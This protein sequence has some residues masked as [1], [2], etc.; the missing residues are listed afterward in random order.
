[1][2][3]QNHNDKSMYFLE[4]V[5]AATKGNRSHFLYFIG[6][7]MTPS[8]LDDDIITPDVW[9]GI[10]GVSG[11]F[12]KNA[13]ID[14]YKEFDMLRF[15]RY[16]AE[17][18]TY[19]YC[20]SLVFTS[21][22]WAKFRESYGEWLE[23]HDAFRDACIAEN[24]RMIL[25][26]RAL[27]QVKRQAREKEQMLK[28]GDGDI[29]VGKI[30]YENRMRRQKAEKLDK[31]ND[32]PLSTTIEF[33]K[34]LTTDEGKSYGTGL[35]ESS[36]NQFSP[37]PFYSGS[38]TTTTYYVNN[39]D[40]LLRVM[41]DLSKHRFASTFFVTATLSWNPE[42]P[43][44]NP[45]AFLHPVGLGNIPYNC[46]DRVLQD[47][48][49]SVRGFEQAGGMSYISLWKLVAAYRLFP[50]RFAKLEYKNP[51]R[52]SK[53]YMMYSVDKCIS[54]INVKRL[55]SGRSVVSIIVYQK[56]K[57]NSTIDINEVIGD[58]S[59]L[60]EEPVISSVLGRTKIE[61]ALRIGMMYEKGLLTQTEFMNMKS[62]LL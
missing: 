37:Y 10:N 35:L 46:A 18:N 42:E 8:M 52:S 30:A 15:K 21:V 1:M 20:C 44:S 32:V 58:G 7:R 49:L 16:V 38:T 45:S 24:K 41:N 25:A 31:V 39:R 53:L 33:V 60:A 19:E 54:R 61:I 34:W 6:H 11:L 50:H 12:L 22:I 51:K 36:P 5:K 14:F 9:C 4:C 28:M 40:G 55:I 59:I 62:E 3:T 26:G 57:P 13:I 23:K 17:S 2:F 29:K 56:R 48:T 47:T 43:Y 27:A